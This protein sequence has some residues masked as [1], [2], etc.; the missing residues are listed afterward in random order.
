MFL[1]KTAEQL[2]NLLNA[3]RKNASG[4]TKIMMVSKFLN[5]AQMLADK[6]IKGLLKLNKLNS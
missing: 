5:F 4:A 3:L 6:E 2:I 1:A